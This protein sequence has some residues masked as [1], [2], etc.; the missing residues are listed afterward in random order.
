M[1]GAARR[2]A[3]ARHV[4]SASGCT[5]TS[6]PSS[7]R[8]TCTR[9]A[10][11]A[12]E[13]PKFRDGRAYSLR[14][15]AARALRLQGRAARRR[16]RADGA[17]VLHAA[18]G[19]R[20]VRSAAEPG[21]GRGVSDRDGG[22]QRLV[23]A[24]RRRPTHGGRDCATEDR[25]AKKRPETTYASLRSRR[26]HQAHPR[27]SAT[28]LGLP[29]LRAVRP[30]GR[31]RA[32]GLGHCASSTRAG[33]SICTSSR[34]RRASSC[35]AGN[36]VL[37][38]D[39]RGYRLSPGACGLIPV[40]MKHAWLG[41]D[42]RHRALDR[43]ECAVPEGRELRRRHLLPRAAAGGRDRGVRHPRS[44]RRGICSAW[45]KTTSRS[46]PCARV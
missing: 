43:H 30:I 35:V 20:R 28:R 19:L 22:F 21:S 46:T 41:P 2:A 9:F 6:R 23:S 1:A 44:V 33:E 36:P 31:R 15:S 39:G 11:I 17:A 34:S 42:E 14:A 25:P 16:R 29:P 8:T 3:R 12:L 5:A 7:S 13:F 40:G 26:R 18:H 38:L 27:V 10:L 24:D 45:A 37:I 32:L 4:R